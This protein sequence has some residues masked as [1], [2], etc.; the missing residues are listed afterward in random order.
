MDRYEKIRQYRQETMALMEAGALLGWDLEVM[1]PA[2]GMKARSAQTAMIARLIH[3]RET[4]P[5]FYA[6]INEALEKETLSERRRRN[7]LVLKEEIEKAQK[8]P[9]DFVEEMERLVAESFKAWHT[10]RKR[11]DFSIFQP[12]LEKIVAKNR[13]K[14][15]L[16]GYQHHP[17][18][19]LIDAFDRQTT[20]PFLDRVFSEVKEKLTP[21]AQTLIERFSEPLSWPDGMTFP[22]D[23]QIA[24]GWQVLKEIG[25]SPEVL[26]LDQ[27]PHPFCTSIGPNDMRITTKVDP[28]NFTTALFSTM[29]EMG[30]AWYDF[31]ALQDEDYGLPSSYAASLSIHESQSLFWEKYVGKS[32]SFLE[33]HFDDLVS[34]FPELS[35]LSP[36]DVFMRVNRV[37]PQPIRIEADEVTYHYHIIV[38]YELEKE[39]IE[40]SLAV[41][42]LPEAWNARYRQYLGLDIANDA[43]GVLQDIHWSHGTLGYFPTYSLGAFYAAQF[44][45]T[46]KQSLDVAGLIRQR[47]FGPILEWLKTNIHQH[48]ALYPSSE[49]CERVTGKPLSLDHY[50]SYIREKYRHVLPVAAS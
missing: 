39:L 25:F 42:D 50:L 6:R 23:K 46:M 28:A 11:S 34:Y 21:L 38:R 1:M 33:S 14:A 30:H 40:G 27:A 16:L 15:E 18:E 19:A 12:Y 8:L 29:H 44:Y 43:E 49:L 24:L 41:K 3:N 35:R 37:Y 13:E 2:K 9:T 4:A 5:D 7:L 45:A 17:Y 48:G 26:R 20:V 36:M 22:E 10:A 31:H 47:N 32:M